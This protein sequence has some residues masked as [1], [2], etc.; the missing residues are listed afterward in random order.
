MATMGSSN[1]PARAGLYD[2]I[3]KAWVEATPEE[4]VRQHLIKQL[5]KLGYPPALMVV[6]KA[7]SELPHLRGERVPNRRLDLLC[8][9]DAETPL[10]L[11]ECKAERLSPDAKRQLI[12]YNAFVG[13]PFLALAS[14]T[15]AL[16]GTKEGNF[17][18]GL[19][20]YTRLLDALARR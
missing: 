12:G 7:L 8:Y 16:F 11:V 2:P 5:L 3:R 4:Q 15:E 17:I 20:P 9:A 18:P 1:P 14:D 10:L 13:A 19:V 6:E